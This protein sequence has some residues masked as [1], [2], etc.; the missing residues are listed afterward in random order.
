[1]KTKLEI[2]V[3]QDA[4]IYTK[5]AFARVFGVQTKRVRR[6]MVWAIGFWVWIEGKRP[7]LY[8]KSIFQNHFVNFRKESANKYKVVHFPNGGYSNSELY[9]VER[10]NDP[11][12]GTGYA[13]SYSV[14]TT[15]IEGKPLYACGCADYVQM[16]EA[17]KA[18]ACKHIYAVLSQQGFDSIRE[19]I[20]Q[21]KREFE[22]RLALGI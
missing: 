3:L 6:V 2:K 15:V 21:H 20:A 16:A 12:N 7:R 4:M 19:S 13:S 18:P 5:E 17:F 1:M 10:I 8:K 9:R 14:R 22:A 11:A